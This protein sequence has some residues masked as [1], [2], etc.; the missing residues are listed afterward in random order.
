MNQPTGGHWPVLVRDVETWLTPVIERRWIDCTIGLGGHA[1]AL[2]ERAPAVVRLLA[3]D[4]DEEN[5][6]AAISNL[7]AYRDRVDAVCGNFRDLGDILSRHG[8]EPADA[9]LADLGF[10]SNQVADPGR[11]L[12]FELDG[13]LDMRLDRTLRTTA[14]DLVNRLGEKQL[15]DL[16][17]FES[18]EPFS[19]RISKLICRARRDARITTTSQLAAIVTR[20][21][22]GRRGRL[23][24]ATRTFLA[25]RAAVNREGEALDELL[26]AAPAALRP[27]GRIA[28]ISFHS[29]EDRRV[30]ESFRRNARLGVYRL[31]TRSPVTADDEEASANPRSRSAKLRV[32][33]RTD[34]PL[35][36]V[37]AETR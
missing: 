12:S 18:Q 10:S 1:R 11:G 14:A 33:E 28:I 17:Y 29:G 30:K 16:L 19:R 7:D 9:I 3:L 34:V 36:E 5:L 31:L 6:A 24:P 23:H 2:F 22:G 26:A 4:V 32:A 35:S 20:A 15:A 13:P 25:L 37:S 8:I 21:V 27:G